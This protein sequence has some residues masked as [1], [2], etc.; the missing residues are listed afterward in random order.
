MSWRE[1][2][3]RAKEAIFATA[4]FSVGGP[5]MVSIGGAFF[6]AIFVGFDIFFGLFSVVFTSAGIIMI[7]AGSYA[8]VTKAVADAVSEHAAKRID[9]PYDEAPAPA[10][11]TH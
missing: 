3:R 9:R 1:A 6:S 11:R 8:V 2:F 7:M 5:I 10:R 4:V